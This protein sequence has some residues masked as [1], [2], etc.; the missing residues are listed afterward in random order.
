[1][2][3]GFYGHTSS[4]VLNNTADDFLFTQYEWHSGIRYILNNIKEFTMPGKWDDDRIGISTNFYDNEE[5]DLNDKRFHRDY[6]EFKQY[7]TAGA[8]Y[9]DINKYLGYELGTVPHNIISERPE[10]NEACDVL[11]V[12]D[13]GYG[14][15]ELPS[16]RCVMYGANKVMPD[17]EIFNPI[18]DNAFVFID[19]N[20]LRRAGAMISTQ[21]SWERT[22]SELIAEMQQNPAINYLLK[23]RYLFVTFGCDGAVLLFP[24][25]GE[26]QL[27]ASLILTHGEIEGFVSGEQSATVYNTN[28]F[29]FPS[30]FAFLTTA[31]VKFLKHFS[32]QGQDASH[33]D[34]LMTLMIEMLIATNNND[35]MHP[36]DEPVQQEQVSVRW[37]NLFRTILEAGE[38]ASQGIR[39]SKSETDEDDEDRTFNLRNWPAFAIPLESGEQGL[40]VPQDWT[41]INSVKERNIADVAFD[42]VVRGNA[43]IE[44]LP[45]LSLGAFTTVD[46]WEI[47]SY[48]NI[49][50]LML[51]Y[52]NGETARPL[53]IA[54]FGS[55]GSGKSFGVTQIAQNI[56]PGKIEK[57]EFNVSQFTSLNDLSVAFQ[58]V[59]DT[60]L[61][62]KLP[63][64]F[65]DEFDS[66]KD[67]LPLG[68]VKSFL[69]PMQD[70]K[71]KDSS[72]D[73]PLGRCILVFAG[74]TAATFEAFNKDS[75]DFK[76]I[77][78]PDFVSR[79][80]GTIN[81]LGP[82]PRDAQDKNYYLRRAL[83]L[84]S[85]CDRRLKGSPYQQTVNSKIIH[86]MLN[87][88][89][90]K[91]GARSMEAIMDMSRINGNTWEP[92]SLPSHSQLSLHVDADIFINLVLTS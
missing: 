51:D 91:H 58:Q 61:N 38:S 36:N 83:L 45:K 24:A 2:N 33:V 8:R 60:I 69:M 81:V 42:Y 80:R 13:D 22:V 48:Q 77:K 7:Q 50:N 44:G 37:G 12:W 79:L 39:I 30:M 75:D 66:D 43:A 52:A 4:V 3:I 56:L 46:R 90:F 76:N 49:K 71:F 40:K 25:C 20:V 54:V 21:V 18:A 62:G 70:G 87:V 53:S 86:A 35:E 17:P 68:W 63:L 88:P 82:N 78:G 29:T 55:P 84:R 92:V 28:L 59:R 74:G 9:V 26:R 6:Y 57:L 67:G 47:E 85:L 19:A 89:E 64:V 73:H 1:M 14:G 31:A 5:I 15:L 34:D 11:F 32:E 10:N 23:A 27:E 41:I 16:S 65:F 72:G